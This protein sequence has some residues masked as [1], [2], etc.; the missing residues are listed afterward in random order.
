MVST[1]YMLFTSIGLIKERVRSS[2][3]VQQVKDLALPLQQLR[4]L[5]WRGFNPLPGTPTCRRH[6]QGKKKN[7]SLTQPAIQTVGLISS[8][9][10]VFF[11]LKNPLKL[12]KILSWN[13][14]LYIRMESLNHLTNRTRQRILNIP[15][16]VLDWIQR[17]YIFQ[18]FSYERKNKC[19]DLGSEIA[20]SI[21]SVGT[22]WSLV[23]CQVR[24][25]E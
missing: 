4:S 10:Q 3:V 2:L 20:G 6:S 18:T 22:A 1:W 14:I 23:G 15:G 11:P 13:L 21:W 5:L 19:I 9:L 25:G 24:L 16:F 17:A 7:V 12:R 8:Y